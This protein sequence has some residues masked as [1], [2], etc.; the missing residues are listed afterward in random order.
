MREPDVGLNNGN[1]TTTVYKSA[2]TLPHNR[3]AVYSIK[4][5]FDEIFALPL[6]FFAR[7]NIVSHR[8]IGSNIL[9]MAL[10]FHHAPAVSMTPRSRFFAAPF[11]ST[12]F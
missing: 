9:Y 11:A 8:R 4:R 7:K 2:T 6:F 12:K 5:Q 3:V 10:I 1:I